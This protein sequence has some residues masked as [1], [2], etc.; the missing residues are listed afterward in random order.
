MKA[1]SDV[2]HSPFTTLMMHR[3]SPPMLHLGVPTS[4][5]QSLDD[6]EHGAVQF[7]M[8]T[9]G[10]L[11]I[12]FVKFGE[13]GWM[14]LPHHVGLY[15]FELRGACEGWK[16]GQ[17]LPFSLYIFD[18]SEFRVNAVRTLNLDADFSAQLM[19]AMNRQARTS[20]TEFAYHRLIQATYAA[21]PTLHDMLAIATARCIAE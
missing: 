5:L 10:D 1:N 13:A 2:F 3:K 14:A 8:A 7:A 19:S 17:P 20:M 21:Y 12:L 16:K 4:Q 15:P 6:F 9:H 18:D 11:D